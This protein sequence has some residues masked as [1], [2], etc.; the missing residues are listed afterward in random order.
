MSKIKIIT[1]SACDL[2]EEYEAAHDNLDILP[3]PIT[4]DGK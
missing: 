3:I 4:I 2:P 1:D